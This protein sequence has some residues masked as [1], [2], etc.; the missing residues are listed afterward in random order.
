M[1]ESGFQDTS[2]NSLDLELLVANYLPPPH[3]H[4]LGG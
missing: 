4:I 3:T 1:K 2:L